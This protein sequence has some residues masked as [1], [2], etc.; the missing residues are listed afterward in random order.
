MDENVSVVTNYT[1][2][3]YSFALLRTTLL[4][5]RGSRSHKVTPKREN[6]DMKLPVNE[7]KLF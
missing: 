5:I 6:T 4:C 1:R 3:K 2:T 7:A